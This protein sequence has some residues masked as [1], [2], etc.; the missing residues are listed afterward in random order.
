MQ[1]F[2]TFGLLLLLLMGNTGIASTHNISLHDFEEDNQE[3]QFTEVRQDLAESILITPVEVQKAQDFFPGVVVPVV[4]SPSK[5]SQ[6]GRY[7]VYSRT[8]VLSLG[9]ADIIFPFHSFL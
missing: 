5:T 8:I 3:F 6:A 9:I 4:L 7:L 2:R 1:F